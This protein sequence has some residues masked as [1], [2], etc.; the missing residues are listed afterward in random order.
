MN[1][2]LIEP[3]MALTQ[4]YCRM[5]ENAGY[6]VC[7]CVSAQMAI[8]CA[9]ELRPDVVVMELQLVSHSGVEFL[10]EF[11]SYADWQ[12]IPLILLT[13]VPPA[14]FSGSWLLL[15]NELHVAKYLYKPQTSLQKLLRSVNELAT[16]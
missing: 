4:T 14:E 15:S 7:P 2:L 8:R 9:D 5:L 10:Y 3:D 11:R 16:I 1:V 13:L 6:T 12:D